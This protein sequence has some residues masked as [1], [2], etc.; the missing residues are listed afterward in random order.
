[1]F[2]STYIDRFRYDRCSRKRHQTTEKKNE[3]V[4]HKSNRYD[5]EETLWRTPRRI[6]IK[7]ITN[8]PYANYAQR[9]LVKNGNYIYV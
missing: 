1:M 7:F 4:N 5:K 3:G 8:N 9:L 2:K 6:S